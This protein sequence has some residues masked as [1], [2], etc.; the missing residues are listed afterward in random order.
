MPL[1]NSRA[2][3]IKFRR[4]CS[5]AK[6]KTNKKSLSD[7]PWAIPARQAWPETIIYSTGQSVRA[8]PGR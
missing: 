2:M 7:N 1:F 4:S 3:L 8:N 6:K 5:T